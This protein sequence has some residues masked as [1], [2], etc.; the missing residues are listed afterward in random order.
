MLF[1]FRLKPI[2]LWQHVRLHLRANCQ[3][4][5]QWGAQCDCSPVGHF[6]TWT[7]ST[8]SPCCLTKRTQRIVSAEISDCVFNNPC[9]AHVWF[10]ERTERESEICENIQRECRCKMF[11]DKHLWACLHG[12]INNNLQIKNRLDLPLQRFHVAWLIS[13]FNSDPDLLS[14][15]TFS[16]KNMLY[17]VTLFIWTTKN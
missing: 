2:T 1:P 15:V 12:A 10:L 14:S 5:C 8:L 17:I 6:W 11:K 3:R 7:W 13:I 9:A 16:W 4:V